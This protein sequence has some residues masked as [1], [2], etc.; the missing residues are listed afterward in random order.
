VLLRLPTAKEAGKVQASVNV[1]SLYRDEPALLKEV[2][3]S[4]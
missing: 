2:L 3:S 4:K 1:W